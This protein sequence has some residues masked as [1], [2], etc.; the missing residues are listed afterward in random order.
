M[1]HIVQVYDFV[2]I[3]IWERHQSSLFGQYILVVGWKPS[4]DK[5]YLILS[6][7]LSD[8]RIIET[9]SDE[10]TSCDPRPVENI[11]IFIF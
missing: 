9:T 11:A 2:C 4:L 10:I 3:N 8:Y 5:S 7:D 1:V 6:T